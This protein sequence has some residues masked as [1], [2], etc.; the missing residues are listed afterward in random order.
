MAIFFFNP[1]RDGR[2]VNC[3]YCDEQ[4]KL[5]FSCSTCRQPVCLH[6][7]LLE[8]P[9]RAHLLT[10]VDN[11]N[12]PQAID[13]QREIGLSEWLETDDPQENFL[14][15]ACIAQQKTERARTHGSL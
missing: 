4:F 10:L 15:P 2:T 7:G 9:G 12:T 3:A 14:C 6:C 5:L 11:V 8:Q 1:G 13:A